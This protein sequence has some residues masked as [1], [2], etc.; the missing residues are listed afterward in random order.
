MH[1]AQRGSWSDSDQQQKLLLKMKDA[2]QHVGSVDVQI[3]KTQYGALTS[4]KC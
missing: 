2:K 4:I 3:K 1:E